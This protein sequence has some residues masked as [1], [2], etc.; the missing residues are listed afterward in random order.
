M[1]MCTVIINMFTVRRSTSNVDPRAVKMKGKSSKNKTLNQKLRINVGPASQTLA[2][3]CINT[4]Q[5]FSV[6]WVVR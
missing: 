2:Q 4:I 3:R 6:C 5:M 1:C